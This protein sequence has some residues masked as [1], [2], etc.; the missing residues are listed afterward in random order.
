MSKNNLA[1]L[2]DH[3]MAQVSNPDPKKPTIPTGEK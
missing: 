2:H 1:D 3:L